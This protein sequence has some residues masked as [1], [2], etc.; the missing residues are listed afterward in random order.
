MILP[1][2]I[3]VAF[4]AFA[5]WSVPTFYIFLSHKRFH[6][7]KFFLALALSCGVFLGYHYAVNLLPTGFWIPCILLAWA[8][9]FVYVLSFTK[10]NAI[11]SGRQSAHIFLASE[12]IASLEWQLHVFLRDKYALWR[13]KAMQALFFI[14]LYAVFFVVLFFVE[15]RYLKCDEL[16]VGARDLFVAIGTALIICAISNISFLSIDTPISGKYP[17]EILYI[18]TLVDLCGVLLL[19]MQK[20]QKLWLWARTEAD[21]MQGMLARQYEQYCI[22]KETI[23]NFNRKYHDF[24]HQLVAIRAETDAEK[25]KAY[26]DE[27]EQSIKTYEAQNKTGNPVLDILLTGKSL[28]CAENKINFTCVADGELLSFMNVVDVCSL[29]GNA[30][31]NAIENVLKLSEEKRLIKLAVFSQNRFLLIQIKN[32]Y[33]NELKY[34]NGDLVTSKKDKLNHGYG[35]KS[36]RT[37]AE[38]YEGTVTISTEDNWFSLSVIIPLPPSEQ[39]T[40]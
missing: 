34:E 16:Y 17:T 5:K 10:T 3:P 13:Y 21:V 11:T 37:V 39:K 26:L 25:R 31:D 6:G 15:R 9:I 40:D 2:D 8:L 30:L 22:S 27:M 20:E 4:T 24:K 29:F 38:K 19:F 36:I 35:I 33:A 1:P 12:F 32:Y 23:D 18:R 14:A 7:W 28:I